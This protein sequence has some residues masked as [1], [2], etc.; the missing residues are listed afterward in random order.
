MILN[1]LN[2]YSFF[3]I[4]YLL[5]LS[6]SVLSF[7][8]HSTNQNEAAKIIQEGFKKDD[9][10]QKIA[11]QEAEEIT[12]SVLQFAK[13]I[14]VKITTN[15]NQGSGTLIG[16][17]GDNYLVLTNAHVIRDNTKITI[18]T[19]DGKTYIATQINNPLPDNYDLALLQF[20]SQENYTIAAKDDIS[21]PDKDQPVISGGY[22]AET[23]KFTITKGVITKVPNQP[24]KEGYQIGYTN[25]INQGM[26]GGPIINSGRLL[27]GINGMSAYP[28]R[29]T[30][31]VYKDGKIPNAEEIKRMREVSWGIPINTLLTYIKPEIITA[32]NLPQIGGELGVTTGVLT[33]GL[34][35]LETKARQFIVKIDS[36]SQANGSGVIIAKS[37]N[38]YTVLTADHVVCEKEGE[39]NQSCSNYNYNILTS[40]GKSYPLNK[41]TII[42]Q[43]GVDLAVFKFDSAQNYPVAQIADYNPNKND[44]IFVAGFPKVGNQDPK[45]MFSG[46]LVFDKERGLLATRRSDYNTQESANLQTVS[47]LSGGYEL[48]YTSITYGGMSGG[49]VLDAEGR[50]I[51]IH[52]Q[53]EGVGGGI[54]LG[55]SLG[56][57]IS[58]F[59]GLKDK[60]KANPQIL[61]TTSPQLNEQQ[62]KDLNNAIAG[63]KVP[64]S[65]ATSD[66]WIERGNQLWRLGHKN[67][68]AIKA[69]DQAI[70]EKDPN[71]IYLAWYGKGLALGEQLKPQLSIEAL[72]QAIRNLPDSSSSSYSKD[73]HSSILG[74]QTVV[75]RYLENYKEGLSAINKAIEIAPNNPNWYNEKSIVLSKLNSYDQAIEAIGKAIKL[76]PRAAFYVNRG[77]FYIQ[78]KKLDLALFD[79]N[80]AL[81]LNPNLTDAYIG[82][83]L[84]Y[85]EQKK[86]DLALADFNQTLK[87][88]PN[89]ANGYIGRA[90]VYYEQKKNDLALADFN[91][92]LKINAK[93]FESYLGR[94]NIYASQKKNDLALADFNQA[95]KI[96]SQFADAYIGRAN[97]YASQKKNDLALADFNQAIKINSQF[98]DAYIGRA[99][100]YAN[101]QK[102]DLALADFAQAIK[103]NPNFID[104]YIGRANMYA[105]GQKWDLALADFAQALKIDNKS[106]QVYLNRGNFYFNQQKWDLARADFEQV[107]KLNDQYALAYVNIGNIYANQG[108]FDLALAE[109]SK[110]LK[111]DQNLDEAYH[112]RGIIYYAQKRL[113]LALA[114]FDQSLK[115]NDQDFLAYYNRG[116]IYVEQKKL[117]LALVDFSQ[118][119]KINPNF[120]DAYKNR[121]VIYAQLGEGKKAVEDVKNA[122]KLYRIKGNIPWADKMVELL[123]KLGG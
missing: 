109:Y 28:I 52:G 39:N 68:E 87:M 45:W 46:G 44:Y 113:D 15:D 1:M 10:S 66:I 73:F 94:A 91:Q 76:A 27:V 4:S 50:L 21:V 97:I 13:E 35:N 18:Q 78:Q 3:V 42:R 123:K 23:H 19:H 48:V 100:I 110:A 31:Y 74:K 29:N 102:W 96:N 61:K 63:V 25:N 101:G 104:A 103:I 41:S 112:S 122:E 8:L 56:V 9:H 115:L 120:A 114:D 14:A 54:Q 111:I 119:I 67:E 60:F 36:S 72:Q 24:L 86:L 90:L 88:N 40:D 12:E 83:G 64:D 20:T 51:G 6:P 81:K 98:A 84:V 92:S 89:F 99:N 37:G 7:N 57:P 53:S 26:S 30:A 107:I 75:Y 65:N 121:G 71:N 105:N 33:G 16:K 38:T 80:E 49:A 95:I 55:Y 59:V 17:Q 116:N 32:F 106:A 108:K 43:E 93:S 34:A 117:D 70:K 58:T 82:R 22:D 77:N 79:F 62:K 118:V 47:S 2:K 85:S 5:L 69:F 11:L